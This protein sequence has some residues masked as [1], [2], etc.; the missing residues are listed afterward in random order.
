MVPRRILWLLDLLVLAFAFLAAYLLVPSVQPLFAPGATLWF[1][2]LDTLS[3]PSETQRVLQPLTDLSW[4]FV[5]MIPATI[6]FLEAFGCYKPLFN[7]SLKRLILGGILAPA[8]GFSIITFVLF[9]L[10][11][12]GWSR[13]FVF[14]FSTLTAIGLVAYRSLL[15]S[16]SIRRRASGY[17]ARNVVIIGS[18]ES[19]LSISRHFERF[20]SPQ[21]YV[22]FGYA[23][24]PGLEK[25]A[26]MDSANS[27]VRYLGCAAQLGDVLT[28]QPIHDVI[29]V[30]PISGGNW[31]NQVIMDCDYLGLMLRIIPE[32]LLTVGHKSLQALHHADALHLPAIV[33]APPHWN[34]EALFVKRVFDI[35]ASSGLLLIL[36]PL[37]LVIAILIKVSSP[38]LPVFY[39]WRVVGRNGANFTGYKFTTMV[40]NADSLKNDLLDR[41]EMV[42]PVFKLKNDPRTTPLGAFLRKYSFNELPQLWSVLKGDMSLVGPR[43]AFRH[44]LERYE[45]WHKRKL[46]INPGITCLWQIRG[47]NKIANFDDWVRMDLEYIDNWSLW[48]DLKILAR[49]A[50]VVISGTGS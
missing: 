19:V 3:V 23:T 26:I 48:L 30:A 4:V 44:E 11:N 28:N 45:F 37:F 34:S 50:L 40:A 39:R 47:R 10:K 32:A 14:S 38:K 33:L 42:G 20:V 2:A 13:L 25:Y 16:Y 49:T 12:P 22:L 46:S 6:M 27:A 1:P 18:P 8:A 36:S 9:A 31:L 35:V 21:E 17:Y 29:L 15:R 43:P 41:N 24:I 7:V 5:A